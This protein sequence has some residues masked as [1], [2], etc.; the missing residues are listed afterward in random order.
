MKKFI[1]HKAFTPAES[2]PACTI[3]QMTAKA[4]FTLAE[5]FI[6]LAII[7]IVAALTIPALV[8]NHNQKAWNT[9]ASVF[10]KKLEEA[11]RQMNAEEKLAGYK[12]TT[13]FVN[14]LKKYIKINKIC[15]SNEISK[16]FSSKILN[17][18]DSEIKIAN[19]KTSAN[20]TK[21]IGIAKY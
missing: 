21:T 6:T 9:A 10:E 3:T 20:F 4:A 16:C 12:N 17:E 13:E 2:R 15:Q 11:T 5:V 19:L 18:S 14:E 1:T 7:G 8:E